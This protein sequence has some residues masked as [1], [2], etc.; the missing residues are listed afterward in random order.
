MRSRSIAN[1]VCG[2]FAATAIMLGAPIFMVGASAQSLKALRSQ[3]IEEGALQNEAAYTAK[4]CG[5]ALTAS[6]D[7]TASGS[8]PEDQSLAHACDGALSAI[9]AVCRRPDAPSIK[10]FICA[11]D[12]RGAELSGSRLRYGA[13][14][15]RD[16]YQETLRTLQ[17]PQ[18]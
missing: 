16:A 3:S 15:G 6:I 17:A 1:G 11:G 8:W 7:W 2:W 18:R 12:G 10:S 14:T 13:G 4:Q 5:D 9:E